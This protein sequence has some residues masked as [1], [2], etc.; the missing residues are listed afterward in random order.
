MS[1]DDMWEVR[2]GG[3]IY[4]FIFLQFLFIHCDPLRGKF[5]LFT[6][7]SLAPPGVPGTESAQIVSLTIA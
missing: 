4:L 1:F 6:F 7:E 2:K 5:I 3:M